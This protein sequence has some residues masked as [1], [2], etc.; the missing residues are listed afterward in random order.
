M[1]IRDIKFNW[2]IEIYSLYLLHNII[3]Q[4]KNYQRLIYNMFSTLCNRKILSIYQIIG[5]NVQVK[6]ILFLKRIDNDN[7]YLFKH[8][9][10]VNK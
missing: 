10:V 5:Y 3:T 4:V 7:K 9:F 1:Y 2:F 8:Y 6:E